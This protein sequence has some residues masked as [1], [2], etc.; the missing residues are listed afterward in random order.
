[1]D[2]MRVRAAGVVCGGEKVVHSI[3][4][5][6]STVST[7]PQ[8]CGGATRLRAG[9]RR[10]N[11][12]RPARLPTRAGGRRATSAQEPASS[13]PVGSFFRMTNLHQSPP[14]M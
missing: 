8:S 12:G 10:A 2:R 1:M 5:T 11:D 4:P 13:W 9:P 14:L 3:A 6:V 7:V